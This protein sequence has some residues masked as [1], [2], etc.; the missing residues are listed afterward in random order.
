MALLLLQALLYDA[1]ND[2][3]GL[4]PLCDLIL[5]EL[6]R[7][8]KLLRFDRLEIFGTLSILFES[9]HLTLPQAGPRV[10]H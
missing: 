9:A 8:L 5:G 3:H 1:A 10:V 6:R 7:R 2:L 4:L